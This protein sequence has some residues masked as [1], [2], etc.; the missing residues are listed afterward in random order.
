MLEERRLKQQDA[1]WPLDA[2]QAAFQRRDR[3]LALDSAGPGGPARGHGVGHGNRAP[4]VGEIEAVMVALPGDLQ[5]RAQLR[6]LRLATLRE[7]AVAVRARQRSEADEHII[8]EETHPRAAAASLAAQSVDAVV[9]VAGAEQRQAVRGDMVE[10]ILDGA[11]R[12][13][14]DA[15]G[16]AR[17][18]RR[19]DEGVLVLGNGRAF[20]I[21]GE[22]IEHAGVPGLLDIAR[23]H[24]GQP[25]M[26]IARP[27]AL[28]DA[29]AAARRAMPPFQ[30][31][32]FKELLPRM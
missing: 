20:E 28:A 7:S 26:R 24:M 11:S 17:R 27:G 9:P 16:L 31:V 30:H 14:V 32:A 18:A 13:F 8:E 23:Q 1:V 10:R 19:E 4:V 5:R 22:N 12:V 3:T 25:E 2:L 6:R 29:R 15:A 21:G